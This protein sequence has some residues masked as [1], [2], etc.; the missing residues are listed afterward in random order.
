MI[1]T[2]TRAAIAALLAVDEGAT[3]DERNRVTVALA[4]K[5]KLLTQTEAARRL[6]V[7]RRTVINMIKRGMLV[8]ANGSARISEVEIN[9]VLC[10]IR[11]E[12]SVA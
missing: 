9:R 11:N 12:R 4:G 5:P 3:D 1:G 10:T 7:S 6:G 8:Q 2:H